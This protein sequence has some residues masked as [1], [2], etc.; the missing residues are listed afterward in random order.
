MMFSKRMR[1]RTNMT[2]Y[3]IIIPQHCKVT[4]RQQKN[5]L[6]DLHECED[7]VDQ[8]LF[9]QRPLHSY[10]LTLNLEH[11][12]NK[13]VRKK[14]WQSN[15]FLDAARRVQTHVTEHCKVRHEKE[16]ES[17]HKKKMIEWEWGEARS[18]CSQ[19]TWTTST[20]KLHTVMRLWI[21]GHKIKRYKKRKKIYDRDLPWDNATGR[22]LDAV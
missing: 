8:F 10:L 15:Y 13:F 22:S 11:F 4:H 16:R 19:N 14:Q 2:K 1:K 5:Q 6:V 21:V 9:F 20:P 18:T 12:L 17:K 7:A 3:L